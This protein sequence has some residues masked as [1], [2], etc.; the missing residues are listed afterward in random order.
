MSLLEKKLWEKKIKYKGHEIVLKNSSK[1]IEMSVD[2]VTQDYYDGLVMPINGL[3]LMGT[4]YDGKQIVVK[5]R[6]PKLVSLEVRGTCTVFYE[7]KE[8]D[9]IKIWC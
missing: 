6:Y 3:D 2:G 9:S 8:V 5:I 7:G 4:T 1:R